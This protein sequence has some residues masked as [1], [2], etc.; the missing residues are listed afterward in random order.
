MDNESICS[1]ADSE[2][3]MLESSPS[4]VVNITLSSEAAENIKEQNLPCCSD[5][6][7]RR[8]L[9]LLSLPVDVLREIV[10]EVGISK[11]SHTLFNRPDRLHT[12][13]I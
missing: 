2:Y 9:N 8:P 1:Q 10:K 7:P 4:T 6:G 5:H 12:R 13:M 3:D 11:L